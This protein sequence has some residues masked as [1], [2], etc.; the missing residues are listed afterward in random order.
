MYPAH[1][2]FFWLAKRSLRP[3]LASYSLLKG[4]ALKLTFFAPCGVL[5]GW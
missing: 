3:V 4:Q 1:Q 5:T 2:N